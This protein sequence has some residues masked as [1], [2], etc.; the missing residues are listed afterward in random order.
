MMERDADV[1]PGCVPG[2]GRADSSRAGY[3]QA[4]PPLPQPAVYLHAIERRV[5]RGAINGVCF[6]SKTTPKA[7]LLSLLALKFVSIGSR[8]LDCIADG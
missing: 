7:G 8:Y 3:L 6:A 1:L 4:T 2:A 5:H